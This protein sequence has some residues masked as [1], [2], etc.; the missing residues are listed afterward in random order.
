MANGIAS[1]IF[2]LYT[3]HTHCLTYD[4]QLSKI[5]MQSIKTIVKFNSRNVSCHSYNHHPLHAPS[6]LSFILRVPT[7]ISEYH[8]ITVTRRRFLHRSTHT[9]TTATHPK[10]NHS[11]SNIV[12]SFIRWYSLRLETHPYMIK[13]LTSGMIAATGDLTCQ[14]LMAST[15][16]ANGVNYENTTTEYEKHPDVDVI[17]TTT[18]N[19]TPPIVE[20]PSSLT[21][22]LSWWDTLRTARFG[23]LGAFFVAPACHV[24]YNQ[25]AIWFPIVHHRAQ[26]LIPVLQRVVLDQFVFTPIFLIGWLSSLSKLESLMTTTTTTTNKN[27]I[28]NNEHMHTDAT[29][30]TTVFNKLYQTIIVEHQ[31]VQILYSNWILWIPVQLCNFYYVPTKY[32]VLTSNCVAFV[33]NMY[34][35][36]MTSSS[37]QREE[38]PRRRNHQAKRNK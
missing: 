36:F 12:S 2:F 24:W 27:H 15:S 10:H 13:G 29:T 38:D 30:T 26:V 8:P 23:L 21:A 37:P 25:L 6:S 4:I 32:Q 28:E 5:S 18:K 1:T 20:A 7:G 19:D 11:G 3:V 33:W 14:Y 35:S 16:N 34:L 22:T 9:N 31:L 17:D